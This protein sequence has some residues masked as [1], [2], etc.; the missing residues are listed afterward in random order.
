MPADLGAIAR[1]Q[2]RRL[3][4]LMDA[5][6]RLTKSDGPGLEGGARF[7]EMWI[8]AGRRARSASSPRN[9]KKRASVPGE[10][11][12]TRVD[13]ELLVNL[14]G[15]AR[16]ARTEERMAGDAYR[17]WLNDNCIPAGTRARA[18]VP[19]DDADKSTTLSDL[20]KKAAAL[21]RPIAV[22]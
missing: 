3:G 21:R 10:D 18:K 7:Y 4:E 5:E 12:T 20:Q 2:F 11:G 22:S 15:D 16:A 1:R 17:K 19:K 13:M 9:L 14:L 6:G 8:L